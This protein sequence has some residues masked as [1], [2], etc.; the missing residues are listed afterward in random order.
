VLGGPGP[1]ARVVSRRVISG[2]VGG[3]IPGSAGGGW[4][5]RAGDG[6]CVSVRSRS[7]AAV[8]AQTASAAMTSTVWRAI[9]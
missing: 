3:I 9:A 5:G 4:L 2:T 1:A 6:A 8:T 7:K